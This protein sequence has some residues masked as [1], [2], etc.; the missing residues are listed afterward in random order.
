MDLVVTSRA[1]RANLVYPLPTTGDGWV[2][3]AFTHAKDGST[4]LYV[5]GIEVGRST[6][7]PRTAV[8]VTGPLSIGGGLPGPGPAVP[9]RPRQPFHGAVDNVLL[10]DRALD[11]DEIARLAAGTRPQAD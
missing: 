4:R 8:H 9:G 1:W 7:R 3:A 6:A 11:R 10:Y 5:D 2:Q